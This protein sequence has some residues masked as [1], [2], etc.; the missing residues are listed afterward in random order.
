M[1]KNLNINIDDGSKTFTINNDPA[2]TIKIFPTDF[3]I[4]KRLKQ[5]QKQ[6]ND[7]LKQYTETPPSDNE[8]DDIEKLNNII[9]EAINHIFAYDVSKAV[10]GDISPLAL[11]NG[12][13]YCE[14]FL[15]G[16]IPVITEIIEEETK[17]TEKNIKKY[18]ANKAVL[19]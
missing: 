9:S 8:E 6:M 3:N 17:K 5:A 7:A 13:F 19:K 16:V 15:E 2:K 12:K 10:F 14:R 18:T 11:A 4:I 1:S